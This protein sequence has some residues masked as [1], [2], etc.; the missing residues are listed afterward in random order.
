MKKGFWA[1]P[2]TIVALAV[3]LLALAEIVDLTIVAVALPHIMGALSCNIQEISLVTTSYIVSAAVFIMMTGYVSSRFGS[4][5]VILASAMVFGLSSIMCGFSQTF[6]EM[7]F[8]RIVQGVGG[9]FL[10]SMAQGYIAANF[11]ETERPKMMGFLTIAMVLGPILG[12]IMGGYLVEHLD[13]RWIFF[14]NVPICITAFLI[15]LFNMKDTLGS[16]TN[17]DALSFGFMAIGFGCL[18]YFIDEGNNDD[19]FYSHKLI[20]ILLIGILSI[21]FF[22]WRGLYGKSVVNFKVFINSNFVFSCIY[23]FIFM[24]A[25]AVVLVFYPTLMQNGY[26]FPVDLAG[27]ISAPRGIFAVVGAGTTI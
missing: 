20:I 11:D 7:V 21:V 12:P 1:E 22:I 15:I 9:A 8:F 23:M 2:R 17:F 10:P 27:Y 14:V 4:K 24:T 25:A 5:K 13:W 16:K 6:A 26:G 3:C 18:E 19:W